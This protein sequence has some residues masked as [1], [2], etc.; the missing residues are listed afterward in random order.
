M[1][2]ND[3]RV[4]PKLVSFSG[5]DGAGKS[6]QIVALHAHLREIG[7]RVQLVTFWEKVAALAQIR[8]SVGHTIFG[9]DNGIGTPSAPIERRDKNVRSSLMTSI[10]IC[11]YV[12]DA[13]ALRRVVKSS[14][15]SNIDVVIFDRY[16]YD[17]L[18]NL[19]LQRRV[20]QAYLRLILNIAP[21]PDIAYLL[22]ADPVQ[23]RIRKPE[24]PLEFV[25]TNR[26]SYHVLSG[27]IGSITVI[28]PMPILDVKQEVL[29]HF[30]HRFP[31]LCYQSQDSVS[32][33]TV[34]REQ[35]CARKAS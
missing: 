28:R 5:I 27:L 35:S 26:R 23:A 24:Y 4:R 22:D 31:S 18:A 9:G 17:E 10:R 3:T 19:P 33:K 34:A 8:A 6:T 21:T 7:L 15:S 2:T 20:I 11:L 14:A 32:F 16:I 12:L 29:H 25:R 30:H 13:I 1:L